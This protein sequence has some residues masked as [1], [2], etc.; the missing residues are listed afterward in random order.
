M[1]IAI[2]EA[3]DLVLD[4]RAIARPPP[5]DVAAEQRR[6]IEGLADAVVRL[7]LVRVIPQKR[8]GQTNADVSDESVHCARSDGWRDRRLQSIVRA[9]SRGG[10]PVLS[11]ASGSARSRICCDEAMRAAFAEPA[12]I[13]AVLA[14][15]ETPAEKGPGGEDHGTGRDAIAIGEHHARDARRLGDEQLDDLALAHR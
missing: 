6:S 1:A 12:A 5:R 8:C 10:V 9:S 4:R 15:E 14:A 13:V 11:R 2:A 7:G 3:A